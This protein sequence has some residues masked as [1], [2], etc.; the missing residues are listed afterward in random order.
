MIYYTHMKIALQSFDLSGNH[1]SWNDR[2]HVNLSVIVFHQLLTAHLWL[3]NKSLLTELSD[4]NRR[5][6]RY[7][8]QAS[9]RAS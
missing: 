5:P 2:S 8:Y 4:L 7:L 9:V 6:M 3:I 1:G